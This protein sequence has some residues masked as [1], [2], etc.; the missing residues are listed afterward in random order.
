M[1]K[2]LEISDE[3]LKLL[4]TIDEELGRQPR[5]IGALE[6]AIAIS[7]QRLV[8]LEPYHIKLS[9]ENEKR[10]EGMVAYGMIKDREAFISKA[11][12]EKIEALLPEL[13]AKI[14]EEIKAKQ[15]A[16]GV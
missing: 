6:R 5:S 12:S 11:V 15:E 8:E 1:Q 3:T 16:F 13:K 9:D 2:R 14:E 4:Q 7:A 10:I